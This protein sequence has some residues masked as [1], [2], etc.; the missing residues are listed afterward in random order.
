MTVLALLLA[1]VALVLFAI[2]SFDRNGTADAR[3][4]VVA[5][6][7]LGLAFLTA[8]LI[9]QFTAFGGDKIGA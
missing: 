8:A 1:L 5:F 9:C 2:S 3:G 7:P 4:R 6:V